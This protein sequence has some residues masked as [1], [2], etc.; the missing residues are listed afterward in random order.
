MP[1]ILILLGGVI[2][3]A[4]FEGTQGDLA[5]ALETD[6]PP[7]MKWAAA[8]VGVGAIGFIPGLQSISRWLMALVI[9][10]LV[11]NNYKNIISSFQNL[12]GQQ[13]AAPVPPTV[14]QQYQQA[15]AQVTGLPPGGTAAG[16]GSSTGFGGSFLPSA[17]AGTG[18]IG[19]QLT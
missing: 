19:G 11:V 8:F 16:T 3:V 17:V 12:G 18:A 2:M 15:T 10:V 6:V 7:Y 5:T 9:T 13:A 1:F 14:E 4:A